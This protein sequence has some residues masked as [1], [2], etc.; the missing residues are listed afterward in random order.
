MIFCV[1]V[2]SVKARREDMGLV[3]LQ[4]QLLLLLLLEERNKGLEKW[5]IR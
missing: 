3:V 4:L 5:I 2:R 1:A